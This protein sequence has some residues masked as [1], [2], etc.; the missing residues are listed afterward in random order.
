MNR[1]EIVELSSSDRKLFPRHTISHQFPENTGTNI[2]YHLHLSIWLK[3]EGGAENPNT[4]SKP[5]RQEV[6]F[7]ALEI[8]VDMYDGYS[9]HLKT[10][11]LNSQ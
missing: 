8:P 11:K 4:P 1:G 9:E 5:L 7:E 6:I 3:D 10:Q 2:E